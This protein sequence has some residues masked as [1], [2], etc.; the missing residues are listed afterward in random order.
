[1]T[2]MPKCPRCGKEIQFMM[3]FMP[4][5]E[6]E[7]C[8]GCTDCNLVLQTHDKYSLT[9]SDEEMDKVRQFEREM[10]ISSFE[11]SMRNHG[12]TDKESADRYLQECREDALQRQRK[13]NDR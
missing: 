10:M 2:E 9:L 4:W 7:A 8:C 13:R 12:I 1:M 5:G 3:M 6:Y 11:E